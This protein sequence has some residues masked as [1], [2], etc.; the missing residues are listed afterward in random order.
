LL[1]GSAE[2]VLAAEPVRHSDRHTAVG[3]VGP[4]VS[5]GDAAF[6]VRAIFSGAHG[7]L[8]EDPATGSLNASLGQWLFASNRVS[9]PYVAAQGTKLGRR[10]RI[11][12]SCDPDG[13]VWIGGRTVTL[14]RGTANV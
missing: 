14:F 8:I 2:A 9:E 7:G 12:V 5:G 11:F 3:L 4:H 13:Q 6:E 10:A 1:L